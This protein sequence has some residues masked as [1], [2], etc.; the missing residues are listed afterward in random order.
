MDKNLFATKRGKLVPPAD[1]KNRAGGKAYAL[2]AKEAL[3]Q[4][5]ATGMFGDTYYANAEEQ[6]DEVLKLA[7]EC[8]TQYILKCAVYAR[9]AGWLKDMPTVLLAVASARLKGNVDTGAQ[10]IWDRIAFVE[11]F[12]RIIDNGK[13]LRNFFQVSRSGVTGRKSLPNIARRLVRE[14]LNRRRG[15]QLMRDQVGESPSLADV[16]KALHPKPVHA[17]QRAMFGYLTGPVSKKTKLGNV[18][19]RYNPDKLYGLVK[20]YEAFKLAE[21]SDRGEVPDVDFRLL[22]SLQLSTAEWKTVFRRAEWQFTRMNLNTALRHD[23][24]KDPEMVKLI[25]DRL[26]NPEEVRASRNFP[27]QLLQAWR[28]VEND[29]P[30]EIKLALQDAM[31]VATENVPELPG[32]IFIALDISGSMQSEFMKR[33]DGRPTLISAL[34]VAA[35]FAAVLMR[36]N[37]R[38]IL[39]PFQT[40]LVPYHK[41]N[42]RDSITTLV[43]NIKRLPSG[44]TDCALPLLWMNGINDKRQAITNIDAV[45][46]LSDY[47]SW[48]DRLAPQRQSGTGVMEQWQMLKQRNPQAKLV[49]L[50]AVPRPH[51]QATNGE[52]RLN[53]GGF[54]DG[55]FKVIAE[56]LKTGKGSAFVDKIE[57][58]DLTQASA[59]AN[60]EA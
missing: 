10:P 17:A 59:V 27:Y 21:V 34:D 39:L 19:E 44:G 56:F 40:I 43:D 5:A 23:V 55:V 48:V 12:K 9:E 29:M 13:M 42:P 1:T 15:S 7:A 16:I 28:H 35:L 53:I 45:I 31:E 58:L 25:A 2:S 32:N 49:C 33:Q 47:E 6:L 26:R 37:P 3:A 22:D 50:D 11:A 41:L 8:S 57:S 51:T 18:V 52:D 30:M 36:K 20:Q 14:W 54:N 38:A 24:L 4:Y 46:Y 60:P